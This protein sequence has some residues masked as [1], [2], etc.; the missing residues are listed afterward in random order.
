MK[1]GKKDWIFIAMIAL[2][3]IIFY[4]ISGKEKTTKV[5]FNDKH[6][7]FYEKAA[8]DG[9]KGQKEADLGCPQCHNEAGGI[10][11]PAKHP[12]KPSAGP[13]SCHLC[14]KYDKS[15]FPGK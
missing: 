4:A 15:R 9:L 1:I 6:M 11:F 7:V 3:L 2:V 5:P 8:K 13:M 10:P 12:V 14:H